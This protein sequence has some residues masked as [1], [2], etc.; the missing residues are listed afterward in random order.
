[1]SNKFAVLVVL[2][3]LGWSCQRHTP[4]HSLSWQQNEPT[5]G[6]KTISEIPVT[7]DS[8]KIYYKNEKIEFRQQAFS[9][10]PIED[11]FVK[12]VLKSDATV[13]SAEAKY[14]I[15]TDLKENKLRAVN[16]NPEHLVEQLQKQVGSA[17]IRHYETKSVLKLENSK[18][19]NYQ[20]VQYELSDGTLWQAYFDQNEDFIS[21]ERLG[22]QFSE[23]HA[24]IYPKGPRESPLT[25]VVLKEIEFSPSMSSSSVLVDSDSVLKITSVVPQLKFETNDDRFDQVQVFFYLDY[26]QNWM[27]QHLAVRFPEK[28]QATVSVGYP[29]LTNTAFYFQ[30]KIRFGRGDNVDY[31][32]LASDPSIVYHESFHALIDGMARLPFE[33]EGGSI[34]EGFAD[35]F[36]CVVLD[37][38]YLAEAS[39]M[40]APYKR[41]VRA[42][43][44]LSEKTGG[45][46]HDSQII[47]SLFWE[48]KE[49]LGSEKALKI[50]TETLSKL[51]PTTNFSDF[52]VQLM[53]SIPADDIVAVTEILKTRGFNYE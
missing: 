39:Y 38:P 28:L 4:L 17:K 18:L 53:R 36:T 47:S 46:Y 33:K 16:N 35:F 26:I 50:A 45:L 6:L 52:N 1:M 14:V 13:K 19:R 7:Q 32:M 2:T 40:K 51:N 44:K 15:T 43:I 23:T 49:K 3:T 21:R 34:N 41:T 42:R 11:S 31:T 29:D 37:R 5:E 9:Q 24:Q 27:K 48:I 22:S 10:Q 30:N 8:T 20:A 12:K 25:E